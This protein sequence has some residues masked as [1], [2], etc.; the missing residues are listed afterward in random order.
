MLFGGS[1]TRITGT[2]TFKV[3]S[4][5]VD[6][7]LS[8]LYIQPIPKQV[9]IAMTDWMGYWFDSMGS[10]SESEAIDQMMDIIFNGI[11]DSKNGERV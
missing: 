2:D 8:F 9:L 6:T 4:I 5:F 3:W 7:L 1:R 10:L 11:L